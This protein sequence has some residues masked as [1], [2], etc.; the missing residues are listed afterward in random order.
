MLASNPSY[1]IYAF[2]EGSIRVINQN[3]KEHVR[4]GFHRILKDDAWPYQP[5]STAQV[6]IVDLALTPDATVDAAAGNVLLCLDENGHVSIFE[7]DVLPG[8]TG[9]ERTPFAQNVLAGRCLCSYFPRRSFEVALR[10]VEKP[11]RIFLHP[12]DSRVFVTVHP[13]SLRLWSIPRISKEIAPGGILFPDRAQLQRCCS[14]VLL[15]K[16]GN[17]SREGAL[18]IWDV[19]FSQLA[20]ETDEDFCD[21]PQILRFVGTPQVQAIVLASPSGCDLRVYRFSSTSSSPVGP[22]LQLVR[23]ASAGSNAAA[24]L[25]VDNTA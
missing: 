7:L 2:K 4:D 11:Q 13:S 19:A 14:T 17:G 15:P 3:A 20:M 25:E 24:R 6:P 22:L 9:T 16:G 1:V 5:A 23:L 12:K 10:D 18:Q 21:V 8:D